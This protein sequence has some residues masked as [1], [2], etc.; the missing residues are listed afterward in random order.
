LSKIV[1]SLLILCCGCIADCCGEVNVSSL[2]TKEY[3]RSIKWP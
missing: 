3:L 1:D 2:S